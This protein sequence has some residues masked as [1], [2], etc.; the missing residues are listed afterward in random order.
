MLY[1]GMSDFAFNP[2]RE[3]AVQAAVEKRGKVYTGSIHL[4]A[5]K[6]VAKDLGGGWMQ[7]LDAKDGF[8]TNKGR[9]VSRTEA[10]RMV[11]QTGGLTAE[12]IK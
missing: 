5:Y 7:H 9:F 4:D 2:P 11:N 10:A 3:R 6:A 1:W 12:H 8:V